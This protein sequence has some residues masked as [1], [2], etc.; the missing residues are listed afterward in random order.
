ML[1]LPALVA[2][3]RLDEWH[4]THLNLLGESVEG[5]ESDHSSFVA[6]PVIFLSGSAWNSFIPRGRDVP[7]GHRPIEGIDPTPHIY[8]DQATQCWQPESFCETP[9]PPGRR[10]HDPKISQIN[11]PA[12]LPT[13]LSRP[14]HLDIVFVIS[15]CNQTQKEK[16]INQSSLNI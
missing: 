5:S 13:K 8:T 12:L 16:I 6:K 7:R 9:N 10:T 3:L 1:P 15:A 4:I 14:C 11:W 2:C